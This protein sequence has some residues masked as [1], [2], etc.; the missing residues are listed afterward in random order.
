[1]ADPPAPACVRVG[2]S[3]RNRFG[4]EHL[5]ALVDLLDEARQVRFRFLNIDHF[6]STK[7]GLVFQNYEDSLL[8][9][10]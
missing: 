9:L 2:L 3:S 10:H 4:D 8:A 1:M 6:H 5:R 7:S